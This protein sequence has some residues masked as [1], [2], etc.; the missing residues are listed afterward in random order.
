MCCDV[1]KFLE[2]L[3]VLS[4]L[5]TADEEVVVLVWKDSKHQGLTKGKKTQRKLHPKE[6]M[7]KEFITPFKKQLK[8]HHFF[9]KTI[10]RADLE[11]GWTTRHLT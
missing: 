3:V 4:N 7:I 5:E 2:I 1:G 10:S 11:L 6:T 9:T 8:I